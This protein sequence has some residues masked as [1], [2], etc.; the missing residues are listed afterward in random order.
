MAALIT[1]TAVPG[2]I[3]Q[4]AGYSTKTVEIYGREL[5]RTTKPVATVRDAVQAFGTAIRERQP[6]I[7]FAILVGV[8]RGD[9]KPH[10]FDAAQRGNGL[11]QDDFLLVSNERPEQ[12]DTLAAGVPASASALVPP[13]A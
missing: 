9:R 13:T 5:A 8:R 1:L 3:E 11:G 10:G 6:G 12:G 7:S 2:H 4:H